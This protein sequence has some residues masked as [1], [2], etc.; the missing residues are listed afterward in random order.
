MVLIAAAVVPVLGSLPLLSENM[1]GGTMEG[2]LGTTMEGL[3]WYI[4]EASSF[5]GAFSCSSLGGSSST[6]AGII[7]YLSFVL[8]VIGL[9][10]NL[11]GNFDGND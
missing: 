11:A 1:D 5:C 3:L 10:L 4:P 6:A 7:A 8:L 9:A 2:A